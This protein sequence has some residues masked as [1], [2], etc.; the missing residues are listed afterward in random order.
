MENIKVDSTNQKREIEKRNKQKLFNINKVFNVKEIVSKRYKYKL[1]YFSR[2]LEHVLFNE[3]NPKQETKVYNVEKF[4]SS[5]NEPLETYLSQFLPTLENE[6]DLDTQYKESW[7]FIKERN[8][9]LK[10]YTNVPLL[11]NFIQSLISEET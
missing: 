6:T 9:S 4:N 1:F 7:I 11:F 8:N 3:P 5:L 10:R 2:N